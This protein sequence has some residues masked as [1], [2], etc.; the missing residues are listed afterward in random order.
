MTLSK[1]FVVAPESDRVNAKNLQAFQYKKLLSQIITVSEYSVTLIG[2]FYN[3]A[4]TAT[5]TLEDLYLRLSKLEQ[6][7][8][9]IEKKLIEEPFQLTENERPQPTFINSSYL[10]RESRPKEM[11][12]VYEKCKR[13]PELHRL[14]EFRFDG[15]TCMQFYSNPN[16]FVEEWKKVMEKENEEKKKKRKDKKALKEEQKKK[17]LEV[18]EV[19]VRKFDNDGREI[20]STPI[21][22]TQVVYEDEKTPDDYVIVDNNE[23]L[24]P[25]PLPEMEEEFD[26]EKLFSMIDDMV[27]GLAGIGLSDS[28]PA[29]PKSPQIPM[30]G[31]PQSFQLPANTIPLK[32]PQQFAPQQQND[33]QDFIPRP[34]IDPLV[35]PQFQLRPIAPNLQHIPETTPQ[36]PSFV[37]AALN[38]SQYDFPVSQNNTSQYNQANQNQLPQGSQQPSIMRRDRSGSLAAKNPVLTPLAPAVVPNVPAPP[39][40][41]SLPPPT[42]FI[43]PTLRKVEHQPEAAKPVQARDGMLSNIKSGIQLK[44]VEIKTTAQPV[45]KEDTTVAGILMRRVALEMSDSDGD[46]HDDDEDWD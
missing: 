40:M 45:K 30:F 23:Q 33:H 5:T 21:N 34:P 15:K 10:S 6:A 38:A 2:S 39:P 27:P 41:V 46:D 31:M 26:P 28:S 14:D 43:Q 3:K 9:E 25:A 29:S 36:A 1:H 44:K 19:E 18:R 37:P 4:E 42:V 12:A 35:R 24:G 17:I 7:L 32:P 16:F 11:V 13:P 8:P 20:H 22:Q